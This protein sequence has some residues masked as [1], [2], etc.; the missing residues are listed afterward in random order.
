MFENTENYTTFWEDGETV[1]MTS[2]ELQDLPFDLAGWT[3]FLAMIAGRRTFALMTL[4]VG[5]K[6]TRAV[7]VLPRK[8]AQKDHTFATLT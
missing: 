6:D 2:R 1:D 8:L 3:S 7:K 5:A 4:H